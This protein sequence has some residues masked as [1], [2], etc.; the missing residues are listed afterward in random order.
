MSRDVP[1]P[2][3]RVLGAI[4]RIRARAAVRAAHLNDTRIRTP[5]NEL[6]KPGAMRGL[7][8]G[9]VLGLHVSSV[10]A[11]ANAERP[12]NAPEWVPGY[13]VRYVL[14]LRDDTEKQT[15]RTVIARLPTG[16]WLRPDAA[17]VLV[18]APGERTAP[19]RVLSHDP[20]GDTLIQFV[21][22]G[23]NRWY[24][25]SAVNPDP[26]PMIAPDLQRRLAEAAAG[27]KPVVQRK[28]EAQQAAAQVEAEL[29]TALR[30]VRQARA[31]AENAAQEIAQW[32][33]MIPARKA[34]AEAARTAAAQAL[35]AVEPAKAAA[36]KAAEAARLQQGKVEAAD[37]AVVEAGKAVQAAE[38][39]LAAA[40]QAANK[41]EAAAKAAGEEGRAAATRNL[42]GA[43]GAQQEAHAAVTAAKQTL[44]Q[45][46]TRAAEIEKAGLPLRMAAAGADT[47]LRA[48][49]D[50]L[51]HAQARE[52]AAR[53][54]LAA[55]ETAVTRAEKLKADSEAT[56][57]EQQARVAPL[58]AQ[59]AQAR[60]IS[61]KAVE[62]VRTAE[63]ARRQAVGDFDPG[64]HGEGLTVEYRE[65]AGDSLE[66]W[67]AVHA[68]LLQSSNVLGNAV[69]AEIRQWFSPANPIAPQH[70]AASYRGTLRI[71][72]PGVYRFLP[73][74]D[75]AAFLFIND[76]LIHSRPGRNRPMGGSA[77]FTLGGGI[78]LEAGTHR[79]EVHHV[80]GDN[81]DA[82][83]GMGLI[84]LR[85]GTKAW[86][87]VPPEAFP[88]A[89]FA[90][91]VKIETA[92]GTSPAVIEY[93]MEDTLRSDG[94]ELF[95][96][97]FEA[98]GD[99]PDGRRLH[100]TFGDGQTG[101]GKSLWHVF[102]APGVY[103]VTLAS[104]P[105]LPPFRRR[106]VVEP[107]AQPLSPGAM[108]RAV[109]A[110]NDANL[111]QLPLPEL[112]TVFEYLLLCDA[113][114]GRPLLE[115]VSRRLATDRKVDVK[116]RMLARA[117]LMDAMAQQGRGTEALEALEEGLK[118][119][120]GLRTL[121][122]QLR[123]AAGDIC[124]DALGDYDRAAEFYT[125]VVEGNR[126]LRHPAMRTAAI[127]LGDMYLDAGDHGKAAESYRLA[128]D[129]A[130]RL[131]GAATDAATRGALL[132]T[133]EQQLRN[134][135]VR[136]TE[137][138]LRR[139]ESEFPEQKLEGLYRFLRAELGRRRGTYRQ[140]E[141]DYE[142]VLRMR[143]WAGYRPRI[144]HGMADTAIRAGDPERAL[145][146]LD[147]LQNEE[148]DYYSTH[149]LDAQRA[150]IEQGAEGAAG[151]TEGGRPAPD[152]GRDLKATPVLR[153]VHRFD[154]LQ[155]ALSGELPPARAGHTRC[156]ISCW[157][158]MGLTS[159]PNPGAP[160][161]VTM[162]AQNAETVMLT[163][164]FGN[165][166][167]ATAL[168][169]LPD[170]PNTEA[171]LQFSQCRGKTDVGPVEIR[172][173]SDSEWEALRDFEEGAYPW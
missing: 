11:A 164:T 88:D 117:A 154:A 172:V 159:L 23:T 101:D 83:G 28:M 119:F 89:L 72:E 121:C 62:E 103:D 115:R 53:N 15:A 69:L 169:T 8:S 71:D 44:L 29:Q 73:N 60:D 97:R 13:R 137:R 12:E 19:A 158:R 17:D 87:Y 64:A 31:T 120:G 49:E 136:Q 170:A 156:R 33:E 58:S 162:K 59:L 141:R 92:S 54:A 145:R 94:V 134:G 75:D 84:W 56:A 167:R 40:R 96:A 9:L 43:R 161:I 163:P 116:V 110:L 147:T 93:G 50:A 65:W 68:G 10:V 82:T 38:E 146:W 51:K 37:A 7:V 139:I 47:A 3:N 55:A 99:P 138:L 106:V 160:P 14:R 171:S 22:Q 4:E 5:W 130:D 26:L 85:P 34:Q 61:G 126:G 153:P 166:R 131:A 109:T 76:Y 128:G 91:V 30:E 105:D 108:Q 173:V 25:V 113:S 143:Q 6:L 46:Q 100:W 77:P 74:G 102:F 127:A 39:R 57:A 41:A 135:D 63:A 112:M 140:A 70:V 95:L 155:Y 20:R 27:M 1:L 45:Q 168:L 79:F 36:R 165:W 107:V 52:E 148:P 80:I 90:D 78:E 152:A 42:E 32:K 150:R 2:G 123:V 86:E 111:A 157:Y 35:Q 133:A 125:A 118:A 122:A 21:A 114:I 151:A 129:L 98:G 16:G 66:D 149:K 142:F 144:L 132:R 81:P 124:R 104:Q 48:A 24:W 18:S 67:P